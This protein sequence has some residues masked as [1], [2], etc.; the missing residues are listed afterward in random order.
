MAR[1]GGVVVVV[2]IAAS[3]SG[4][5]D[6]L[7]LGGA[8]YSFGVDGDGAAYTVPPEGGSLA[9]VR[10]DVPS[11]AVSGD[12]IDIGIVPSTPYPSIDVLADHEPGVFTALVEYSAGMPVGE[13]L[14]HPLYTPYFLIADAEPVGPAFEFTP[15]GTEFTAPITVTMPAGSLAIGDDEVGLVLVR[16]ED[17]TWEAVPVIVGADGAVTFEMDHFSGLS[18]WRIGKN[19]LSNPLAAVSPT[20]LAA[21]NRTIDAGSTPAIIGALT[22]LAVCPGGTGTEP[23]AGPELVPASMLDLLNYLGRDRGEIS[24]RADA[25]SAELETWVEQQ[26][27]A[28]GTAAPHS[29]RLADLFAMALERTEGGVFEALVATHALLRDNRTQPGQIGNPFYDALEPVRG[30]GGDEPGATY[31]LFGMAIYSFAYEYNRD[32]GRLGTFIPDAETTARLEE[33]WVSGDL[34]S[35]AEEYVIDLRGAELGR[36]LYQHFFSEATGNPSPL[37]GVCGPPVRLVAPEFARVDRPVSLSVEPIGD[38]SLTGLEFDWYVEPLDVA[39]FRGASV[40]LPAF[41]VPGPQDVRLVIRDS[42]NGT[43]TAR[44]TRITVLGPFGVTIAPVGLFGPDGA[45]FSPGP[46]SQFGDVFVD[47]TV[48]WTA[49]VDNAAVPAVV[50]WTFPEGI[51]SGAGVVSGAGAQDSQQAWTAEHA[52]GE[53][54]T[55]IVEVRATDPKT[56]DIAE[57]SIEVEVLAEPDEPLTWHAGQSCPTEASEGADYGFRWAVRLTPPAPGGTWTV[58]IFFHDCPNGGRLHYRGEAAEVALH[59]WVAVVSLLDGRGALGAAGASQRPGPID[60][61]L[62]SGIAIR[63]NLQRQLGR[64]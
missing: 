40:Q 46:E 24:P 10:V 53:E 19:F 15:A 23:H 60:Y 39:L 4:G 36:E 61:E 59:R 38:A 17:G 54:G 48:Q 7:P 32:T 29:V 50:E 18:F 35:D 52:L 49:I 64:N 12:P 47:E 34:V 21:A 27:I 5:G 58:D 1:T 26:R 6:P 20:R 43:E 33:G 30:D 2:L 56:G 41:T 51:V 3:C 8:G 14:T 37:R 57:A 42:V 62:I 28:S 16:S 63:P 22:Q 25:I 31:H 9:G 44:T 11:G 55:A 13:S 45:V